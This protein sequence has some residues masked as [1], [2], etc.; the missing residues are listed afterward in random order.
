MVHLNYSINKP[1][2]TVKLSGLQQVNM[3][4]DR[5]KCW[6]SNIRVISMYFLHPLQYKLFKIYGKF[7]N[8]FSSVCGIVAVQALLTLTLCHNTTLFLEKAD[9]R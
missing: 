9:I 7:V 1:E 2:L 3:F 5:V 8:V 4:H 6:L